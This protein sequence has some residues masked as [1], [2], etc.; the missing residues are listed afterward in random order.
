MFDLKQPKETIVKKILLATLLTFPLLAGASEGTPDLLDNIANDTVL[1]DASETSA[2][3]GETITVS[4]TSKRC[5]RGHCW[6]VT[7][8]VNVKVPLPAP[9]GVFWVNY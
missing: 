6:N 2:I 3:R 4:K 1:M 7:K 9:W 8:K 5:W